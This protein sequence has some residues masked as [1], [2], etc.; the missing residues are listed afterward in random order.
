[1]TNNA[2][3]WA[4][5]QL[6]GG[7]RNTLIFCGVYAAAVIGAYAFLHSADPRNAGWPAGW[8]NLLLGI[9]S[10]GLLVFGSSRVGAA[11]RGD[12]ASRMIESH[13]LMSTPAPHAVAGYMIG[14]GSQALFAFVTTFSIGAVISATAGLATDRWILSNGILLVFAVFIW[15]IVAL[16]SFVTSKG[17]LGLG[18][19]IGLFA[20]VS[21]SRG[22]VTIFV[23]AL[24]ILCS[25]IMGGSIFIAP[26]G[27]SAP[28]LGYGASLV[29][30]GIIGTLF[31]F[32]AARRYRSA[33]STG[34]TPLMALAL[35]AAWVALS[36]FAMKKWEAIQPA[37]FRA[38][39]FDRD[40]LP[41][42]TI[43]T[44]AVTMLL[45]LLPLAVSSRAHRQW[46]R[47]RALNDPGLGRRPI[48][49][50]LAV[51]LCAAMCLAIGFF[52]PSKLLFLQRAGFWVYTAGITQQPAALILTGATLLAYFFSCSYLFRIIHRSASGRGGAVIAGIFTLLIWLGP[53]V[54]EA[55][56]NAM[57]DDTRD[58]VWSH[59]AGWSP[60][61]ALILIWGRIGVD[62][63]PGVAGQL[64]VAAALALLFY[65]TDRRRRADVI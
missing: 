51:V 37:I 13:R 36:V 10:F 8:I 38:A 28:S 53:L 22:L 16:L 45:A 5:F 21:I 27:G 14:G 2:I 33:E 25:P 32:A 48:H 1:M 60:L 39:D 42:Q 35:V 18:W 46:K 58:F 20:L 62:A 4:Q 49:P 31:F 54:I 24:T 43:V 29:G 57:R 15:S 55:I 52:V 47:H 23:P 6:R 7:L 26:G 9:Q 17:L 19:M 12:V 63:A 41:I 56:S 64:T 61:G 30:Q 44:T 40:L 65:L 59:V 11:I 34:F 3:A 50:A